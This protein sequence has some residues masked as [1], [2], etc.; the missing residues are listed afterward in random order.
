MNLLTI[1]DVVLE[2]WREKETLSKLEDKVQAIL[3]FAPYRIGGGNL[4]R[5]NRKKAERQNETNSHLQES[6]SDHV[7]AHLQDSDSD[8]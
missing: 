6:D 5:E 2:Q 3:K 8:Q 1:S 4:S 7:Q